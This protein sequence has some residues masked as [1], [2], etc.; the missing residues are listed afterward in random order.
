MDISLVY[1]D[2]EH[3]VKGIEGYTA[4]RFYSVTLKDTKLFEPLVSAALQN[5]A[6]I[7]EGFEFKTTELRKHRDEARKQAVRAAKEK[8]E[9]L[10]AELGAKVGKPRSISEEKSVGNRQSMNAQ[11]IRETDRS[12]EGGETTPLG[13]IGVHARISVTFD[14]EP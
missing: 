11:V 7:I 9:A 13:Q 10:A 14:L 3:F 4:R 5:G 1:R 8:A 6:N 2:Y 12:D